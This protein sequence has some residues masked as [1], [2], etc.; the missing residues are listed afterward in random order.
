[1]AYEVVW[2]TVACILTVFKIERYTDAHGETIPMEDYSDGFVR[3]DRSVAV[4]ALLIFL[5]S[6]CRSPSNAKLARAQSYMQV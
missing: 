1:M 3:Y 2:V 6:A 4:G 5:C